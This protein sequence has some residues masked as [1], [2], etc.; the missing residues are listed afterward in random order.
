MSKKKLNY[1]DGL[2]S[3]REGRVILI[4]DGGA[5]L[6]DELDPLTQLICVMG[7]AAKRDSAV[8]AAGAHVPQSKSI[9]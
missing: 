7:E 6:F 9:H 4:R 5:Y 3:D 1:P 8:A 2:Y